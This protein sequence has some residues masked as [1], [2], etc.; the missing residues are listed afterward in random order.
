MATV[1]SALLEIVGVF[2]NVVHAKVTS[3]GTTTVDVKLPQL[4]LIKGAIVQIL[5]SGNRVATSDADITW[6]GNTMTIADGGTFS[7]ADTM[8]IY[9][10]AW[11]EARR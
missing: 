1:T 5:D 11:G 3:P 2:G 8:T 9:I 10:M 4:T 6:S 7:L